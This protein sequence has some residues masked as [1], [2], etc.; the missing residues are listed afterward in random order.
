M[1]LYVVTG[2]PASGKS[3]WIA[4]HAKH[5]DVVIDYDRIVAAL[6]N[7]DT[8]G[9]LSGDPAEQPIPLTQVA[10]AARQAAINEAIDLHGYINLDVYIVHTTPSRQHM[11]Q[12]RKHGAEIVEMDPGYDECMR[13]AALERTPRQQAFVQDWYER[14]GLTV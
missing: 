2:P 6:H 3:T 8:D 4:K 9:E 12:Y 10:N 7:E 5:G 11:N 14:R 1:T 13:R